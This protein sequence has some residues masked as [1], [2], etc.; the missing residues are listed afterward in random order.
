MFAPCFSPERLRLFRRSGDDRPNLEHPGHSTATCTSVPRRGVAGHYPEIRRPKLKVLMAAV[1]VLLVIACANVCVLL[2]A[3]ATARQRE[4]AILGSMGATVRRI[5][6]QLLT[7]SVILA[8]SGGVPGVLLAYRSVPVIVALM[9]QYS[10]PHEADIHVNGPVVL[11]TFAIS[12]V[13]GILRAGLSTLQYGPVFPLWR[14]RPAAGCHGVVQ[15]GVLYGRAAYP[16]VRHP[17]GRGR[18]VGLAGSIVLSRVTARFVEGWNPRAI[19]SHSRSS[20]RFW[21]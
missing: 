8:L 12:V 15:R 10:V 21:H 3:R 9:P 20:W 19:Q 1:G 4:I 13:I 17:H 18:S 11:L 2:L 14:R 5:L 16:R 7:E 6:Q